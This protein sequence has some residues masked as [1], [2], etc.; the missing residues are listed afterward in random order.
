[1]WAASGGTGFTGRVLAPLASTLLELSGATAVDEHSKEAAAGSG[2][3]GLLLAADFV[4]AAIPGGEEGGQALR[5]EAT[6]L[7]EKIGANR[8]SIRLADGGIKAVDLV[9]RS[10]AGVATPHVHFYRLHVNPATGASRLS[11]VKS[12]FRAATREDLN[13]VKSTLE[14][15]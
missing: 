8:V 9:G 12:A 13:E 15:Q 14:H 6:Q 1:M 3:A 10:H 5:H 2:T 11:K 7:A 4:L